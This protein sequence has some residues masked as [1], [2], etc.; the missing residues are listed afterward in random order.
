M[1]KVLEGVSWE[2][3]V[4]LDGAAGDGYLNTPVE[5]SQIQAEPLQRGRLRTIS[6]KASQTERLE[7]DSTL[8]TLESTL[9]DTSPPR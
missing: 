3:S 8:G 4:R 6:R 2:G 9:W 7:V 5:Y 1:P